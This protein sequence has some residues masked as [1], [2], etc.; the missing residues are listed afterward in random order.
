MAQ[1]HQVLAISQAL[2]YCKWSYR[3]WNN[4]L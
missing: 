1:F 3:R 2:M 4:F